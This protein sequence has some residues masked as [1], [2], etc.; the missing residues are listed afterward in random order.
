MVQPEVAPAWV[1]WVDSTPPRRWHV[2]RHEAS[3]RAQLMSWPGVW[4]VQQTS[5]VRTSWYPKW[6]E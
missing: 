5:P 1:V 3:V 4:Q 2:E 6:Q